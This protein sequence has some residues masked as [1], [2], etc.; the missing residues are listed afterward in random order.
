[1]ATKSLPRRSAA[2]SIT[3]S[4]RRND[5]GML[6]ARLFEAQGIV[7][8]ARFAVASQLENLDETAVINALEVASRIIDE[9]ASKLETR[10]LRFAVDPQSEEVI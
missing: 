8:L 7:Q 6:R 1:M 5:L 4:T 3:R 2:R 10:S 9:I